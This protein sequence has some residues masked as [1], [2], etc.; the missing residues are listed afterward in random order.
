MAPRVL[1]GVNWE[2]L[3][4]LYLKEVRRFWKVGLQTVGAPV[5]TTLLYMLIFVVAVG[6]ARPLVEGVSFGAFVGPGLIMMAILN[7]SFANASSSIIQAK[8][9]GTAPDFL[10]PPLSPFEL[11]AGFGLGAMTRGVLV[12]VVTALAV[13]PF[14]HYGLVH[15]GAVIYYA[16]VA[17]LIMSMTGVL[18]GL[19]SEKFDHLATV[20]NFV[21]MPLSFLSG[22]FY[23]ISALPAVVQPAARFNPFFYLIDGFRYGFTGHADASVWVGATISLA[24]AV[25]LS[26]LVWELFRRGWRLKS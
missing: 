12:G 11:A 18:A 14:S 8:I 13:W 9:M 20:T 26:G 3:K 23:S 17:S 21:I 10:T 25:V 24:L 2:G 7:N 4:T 19:W 22:T 15:A 16:V 6:R 5:V 1:H